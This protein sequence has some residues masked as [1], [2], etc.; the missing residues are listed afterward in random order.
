MAEEPAREMSGLNLNAAPFVFAPSGGDRPPPPPP[1]GPSPRARRRRR[2]PRGRSRRAT[3][4]AVAEATVRAAAEAADEAAIVRATADEAAAARA[5]TPTPMTAPRRAD[6]TINTAPAARRAPPTPTRTP[7]PPEA[8][9]AFARTSSSTFAPPSTRASAAP[10]AVGAAGAARPV[11]AAGPVVAASATIA[12]RA[13]DRPPRRLP[14][15]TLP[16]GQL[17]LPGGGLGGPE[18]QRDGSRSHGGLGRCRSRRGWRQG[19]SLLPRVF[20]R[21]PRVR[22]GDPVRPHLLFPV[23]RATRGDE[24]ARGRTRQ[25]SDVF[26]AHPPRGSSHG[27]AAT[28]RAARGGRQD[29]H[30]A[31]VATP[32]FERVRAPGARRR[33]GRPGAG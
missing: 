33:K 10:A 7:R 30:V 14:Q 8:A 32:R 12:P 27:A 25:V 18:G 4:E 22:A 20:R 23:H 31:A 11:A 24:S 9:R 29:A 13:K 6:P 15:G 3:L 19:T 26:H 2:T 21:T 28:H 1:P 5:A 17:S 16:P